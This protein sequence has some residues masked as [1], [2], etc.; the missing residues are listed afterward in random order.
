MAWFPTLLL[1]FLFVP[2]YIPGN[3]LLEP[4]VI[5]QLAPVQVAVLPTAPQAQTALVRLEPLATLAFF[6]T[7]KE[8]VVNVQKVLLLQ[9]AILERIGYFLR[10]IN[11]YWKYRGYNL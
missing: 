6:R 1:L 2:V 3:A 11:S 4:V 8:P 10:C 7:W 9:G 5:R